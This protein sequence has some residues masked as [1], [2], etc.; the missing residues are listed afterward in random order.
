MCGS[1]KMD[2]EV[3]E[4]DKLPRVRCFQLTHHA[5]YASTSDRTSCFASYTLTKSPGAILNS[6][7]LARKGEGQDARNKSESLT[8]YPG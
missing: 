3:K 5:H 1:G 6:R 8:Q 4:P 7:G 2:K